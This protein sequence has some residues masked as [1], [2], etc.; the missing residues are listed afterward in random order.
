MNLSIT[1][2]LGCKICSSLS[3]QLRSVSHQQIHQQPKECLHRHGPMSRKW[4]MSGHLKTTS[5]TI[6]RL[7]L[8]IILKT[9]TRSSMIL[10]Y[11]PESTQ[12]RFSTSSTTSKGRTN[13]TWLP[14]HSRIKAGDFINNI[15]LGSR[16]MRSRR[17]S[18]RSLSKEHTVSLT[19]RAHGKSLLLN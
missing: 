18:P 2:H 8:R 9:W 6:G 15:K 19:T 11:T 13:S 3:R 10:G 17:Q 1:C 4:L 14:R 7:R 16:D 12:I 5:K